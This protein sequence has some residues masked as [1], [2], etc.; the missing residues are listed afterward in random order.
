[1]FALGLLAG[2]FL[3]NFIM[4]NKN[5]DNSTPSTPPPANS[6]DISFEPSSPTTATITTTTTTASSTSAAA[7]PSSS[8]PP[9]VIHIPADTRRR[10]DFTASNYG[11]LSADAGS[12]PYWIVIPDN[13]DDGYFLEQTEGGISIGHV[14]KQFSK[15]L[16]EK[17]A[18]KDV[19]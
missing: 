12:P 1:M 17:N 5:T 6:G 8:P 9:S 10:Y 13:Q 2:V 7:E 11:E 4:G 16:V 3:V 15:V 18:I 19:R 14:E